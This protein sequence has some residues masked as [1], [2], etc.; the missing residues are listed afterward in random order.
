YPW[1]PEPDRPGGC[2]RG[3]RPPD[4]HS[5]PVACQWLQLAQARVSAGTSGGP[6]YLAGQRCTWDSGPALTGNWEGLS[7]WTPACCSPL[8]GVTIGAVAPGSQPSLNGVFG[9]A[10]HNP[11]WYWCVGAK[12]VVPPGDTEKV[13]TSN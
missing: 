7:A 6:R 10:N 2:P 5:L 12:V 13:S 4:V 1:G 9:L 3:G 8:T 11:R